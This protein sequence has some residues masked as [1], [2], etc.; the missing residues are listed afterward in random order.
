MS[1]VQLWFLRGGGGGGQ[2]GRVVMWG[3][4]R[5]WG[6][7]VRVCFGVQ[8]LNY[9]YILLL[10]SQWCMR[11]HVTL[12][13]DITA[14]NCRTFH[15]F[16]N[17]SIRNRLS[18]LA[19]MVWYISHTF[20]ISDKRSHLSAKIHVQVFKFEFRHSEFDPISCSW[21]DIY[22]PFLMELCSYILIVN[23]MCKW[24]YSVV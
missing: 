8:S 24:S 21:F 13:S 14:L 9:M 6:W 2:W 11:Y 5:G 19:F 23:C 10:S 1:F 4:G 20:N 7:M 3:V 17:T 15:I 18:L 16:T 12:V 22:R